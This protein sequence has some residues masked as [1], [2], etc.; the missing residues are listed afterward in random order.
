M[1]TLLRLAILLLVGATFGATADADKKVCVYDPGGRSGFIFQFMEPWALQT[2]AWGAQATL[3]PYTDEATAVNDFAAGNCDAVAAS[4]V[5]LQ[6][7]NKATYTLEA[8]G[9]VPDYTLFNRMLNALQTKETY[10][11]VFP[12]KG[13]EVVGLYP[14]GAVYAFV[15]DKSIN[16]VE[17]LSGKKVA[18]L[19]YDKTSMHVV[20]KLGGVVVPVD[21]STL[22]PTFNNGGAQVTFLPATAYTP[23]ELWRGLGDNGGVLKYPLLQVTLQIMIHPDRF[24]EGFADQSRAFVAAHWGDAKAAIDRAEGEIPAKYWMEPTASQKRGFDALFQRLRIELK[25]KVGA[26]DGRVLSM[27]KKGRCGSDKA[28]AECADQLEYQ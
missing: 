26:Y 12:S 3:M 8:V 19:E 11:W 20:K 15:N 25:D 5:R 28:R 6:S 7:Y 21:L 22:G 1:S 24:P 4:G 9:G 18:T 13:Y 10:S 17:T 2:S 23:F 16:S 14:L 27:L